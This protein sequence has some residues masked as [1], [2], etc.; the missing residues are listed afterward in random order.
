MTVS[1]LPVYPGDDDFI[2]CVYKH[3]VIL[4]FQKLIALFGFII[5]WLKKIKVIFFLWLLL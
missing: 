1:G 2:D 4:L 5:F 3:L